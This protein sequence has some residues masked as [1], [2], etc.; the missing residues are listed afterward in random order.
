[1]LPFLALFN[2]VR[3]LALQ[4]LAGEL[5][6]MSS[7]IFCHF[8]PPMIINSNSC[9]LVCKTVSFLIHDYV[10]LVAKM[11]VFIHY[12][13]WLHHIQWFVLLWHRSCWDVHCLF[14]DDCRWYLLFIGLLLFLKFMIVFLIFICS[15][16]GA[17]CYIIACV[18]WNPCILKCVPFWKFLCE[19]LLR[20]TLQYCSILTTTFL[21]KD[22]IPCKKHSSFYCEYG[23]CPC[24]WPLLKTP[25]LAGTH[26]Y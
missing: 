5:T 1:M 18:N 21:S 20:R 16:Q 13:R 4:T 25:P 6:S 11:Q 17:N 26:Q 15:I 7:C 14:I 12:L 24:W 3:I 19:A 22:L 23:C 10:L 2:N 8:S 9:A